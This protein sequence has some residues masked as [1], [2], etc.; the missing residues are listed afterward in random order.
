MLPYQENWKVPPPFCSI[1]VI[2]HQNSISESVFHVFWIK[3]CIKI[4][5]IMSSHKKYKQR[6]RTQDEPKGQNNEAC[7]ALEKKETLAKENKE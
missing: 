7:R 5:K 4:K 3:D 1:K 6:R 2:I